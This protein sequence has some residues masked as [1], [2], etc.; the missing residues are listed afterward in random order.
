MTAKFQMRT[1][2]HRDCHCQALLCGALWSPFVQVS[3][4]TSV[5]AKSATI[6]S[7]LVY[8]RFMSQASYYA[9]LLEAE[10]R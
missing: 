9:M 10:V 7:F 4:L 1:P 6:I 5:S 2:G 8:A 3:S